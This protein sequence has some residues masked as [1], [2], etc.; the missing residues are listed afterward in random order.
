MDVLQVGGAH[1]YKSLVSRFGT[2]P[3]SLYRIVAY[4]REGSGLLLDAA[5]VSEQSNSRYFFEFDPKSE[6]TLGSGFFSV[7]CGLISVIDGIL[8]PRDF[9][10]VQSTRERFDQQVLVL[11]AG[12]P[13][14]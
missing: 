14:K 1:P 3:P 10:V 11:G 6:M 9:P 5:L 2:S 8:V 13:S 12:R 7:S 4:L